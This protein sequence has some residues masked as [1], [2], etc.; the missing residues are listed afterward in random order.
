MDAT[1]R[2]TVMPQSFLLS[3]LAALARHSDNV[4]YQQD[5]TTAQPDRHGTELFRC[6]F[7]RVIRR[8]GDIP[9]P[10]PSLVDPGFR[11]MGTLETMLIQETSTH[12]T[13][14]EA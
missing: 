4:Y 13:G 7:H 8:F 10:S 2:Y 11:C 6:L 9:W 14:A 1:G 5:G 3:Q 12:K